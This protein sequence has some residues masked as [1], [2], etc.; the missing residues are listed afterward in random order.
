MVVNRTHFKDPDAPCFEGNDLYDD[1][2][3]FEEIEAAGQ[4][5]QEFCVR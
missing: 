4:D 2:Q 3:G 1:L 5:E